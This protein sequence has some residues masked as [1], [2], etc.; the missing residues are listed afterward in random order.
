M[1]AHEIRMIKEGKKWC[2][3]TFI[4]M[5]KVFFIFQS[6]RLSYK[7]DF[8]EIIS[9]KLS[10][11]QY[12]C[13]W[14]LGEDWHRFGSSRPWRW[15]WSSGRRGWRWCERRPGTKIVAKDNNLG[16]CKQ[17]LMKAN[18]SGQHENQELKKNTVKPVYNDHPCYPKIVAFVSRWSL[19]KGHL[20]NK[21]SIWDLKIVV[22]VDR[23]SLFVLV[24]DSDFELYFN[25][26][27]MLYNFILKYFTNLIGLK[28]DATVLK[29]V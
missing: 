22:V 11:L 18:L 6:N 21:T 25:I 5:K 27:L 7:L 16:K 12:F 13:T 26:I 1:Q 15:P 10:L 19:F 20:Y 4:A 14:L 8:C 23:W 29:T 9:P 3:I 17:S 2:Q 28:A 24:V